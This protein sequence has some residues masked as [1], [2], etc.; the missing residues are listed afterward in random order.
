VLRDFEPFIKKIASET[1]KKNWWRIQS[2]EDLYQTIV[3][4]L[5]YAL[6]IYNEE[7]GPLANHIKTVI[8]LKLKSMLSGEHAPRSKGY[9][10]TFLSHQ[11]K[12]GPD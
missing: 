4:L 2:Y 8:T 12:P 10:F 5:L 1:Y 9:P 3:Y 6:E 11:T 7:K